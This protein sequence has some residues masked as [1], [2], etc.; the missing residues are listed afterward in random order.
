V[1]HRTWSG[2][3][4]AAVTRILGHAAVIFRLTETVHRE[5]YA[6]HSSGAPMVSLSGAVPTGAAYETFHGVDEVDFTERAF[7]A[8]CKSSRRVTRAAEIQ[9]TLGD[10]F[11]HAVAGRPGPTRVEVTRDVL[12]GAACSS[13]CVR[14]FSAHSSASPISRRPKPHL[15]PPTPWTPPSTTSTPR[16]TVSPQPWASNTPREPNPHS[17]PCKCLVPNRTTGKKAPGLPATSNSH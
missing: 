17:T 2:V 13:S 14:V 12:E 16:W 11:A 4:V 15:D 5:S 9:A 8:I 7:A 1:F 6:S 10:A 3:G